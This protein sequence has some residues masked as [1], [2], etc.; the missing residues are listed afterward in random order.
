MYSTLFLV[1]DMNVISDFSNVGVQVVLIV[2]TLLLSY[3][4][5][6]DELV[7]PK[8]MKK[9]EQGATK[10]RFTHFHTVPEGG[11]N[12]SLHHLFLIFD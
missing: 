8:H 1:V 5:Q 4:G 2:Y 3:S 9:L 11:H 12:V 10:A 6:R 7:P